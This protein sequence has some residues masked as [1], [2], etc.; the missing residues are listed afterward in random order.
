[1]IHFYNILIEYYKNAGMLIE[2]DANGSAEE[3]MNQLEN[4]IKEVKN[5]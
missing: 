1:M 2:V 5:D 4:K 3:T